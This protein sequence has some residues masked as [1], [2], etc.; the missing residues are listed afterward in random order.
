MS[1]TVDEHVL[2]DED[3]CTPVISRHAK[4]CTPDI[5]EA[6]LITTLVSEGFF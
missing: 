1:N 4:R 2:R 6:M 5:R 3:V